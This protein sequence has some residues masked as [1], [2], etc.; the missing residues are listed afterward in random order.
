MDALTS[1]VLVSSKIVDHFTQT[2]HEAGEASSQQM[3][4]IRVE[5]HWR[6]ELYHQITKKSAEKAVFRASALLVLILLNFPLICAAF[7]T[8]SPHHCPTKQWAAQ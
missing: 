6:K 4:A 1:L 7:K 8:T 3:Q 5:Q 2:Q